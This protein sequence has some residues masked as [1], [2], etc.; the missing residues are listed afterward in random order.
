MRYGNYCYSLLIAGTTVLLGAMS[1]HAQEIRHVD[2]LI[3]VGDPKICFTCHYGTMANDI[4]PCTEIDCLLTPKT[5]HP[6][7]KRYPPAGKESKF[8]PAVKVEAAG[9][10]LTNGE[11][12]CISCHDLMNRHDHHLVIDNRQ[13]RLC[14][15]CHLR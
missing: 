3:E 11:V 4:N 10:K 6:V 2:T 13:G 14:Q 8:S 15:T 9:I 7:F 1:L 12:T 5:S